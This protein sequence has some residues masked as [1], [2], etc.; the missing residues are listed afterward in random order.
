MGYVQDVIWRRLPRANSCEE[1]RGPHG[2]DLNDWEYHLYELTDLG[3]TTEYPALF[4]T[5]LENGGY[6]DTQWSSTTPPP[7]FFRLAILQSRSHE[8]V[9][10]G[11]TNMKKL[12]RCL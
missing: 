5:P 12:V 4:E 1:G 9:E 3:V 6:A 11:K 7:N 10:G 2:C 8:V